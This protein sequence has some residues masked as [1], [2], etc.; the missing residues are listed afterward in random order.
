MAFQ[1]MC[2]QRGQLGFKEDFEAVLTFPFFSLRKQQRMELQFCFLET[3]PT[4]L[5]RD[6]SPPRRVNAWPRLVVKNRHPREAGTDKD[7][8]HQPEELEKGKKAL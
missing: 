7:G 3:K 5:P 1:D 4:V 2:R 8:Q 6:R